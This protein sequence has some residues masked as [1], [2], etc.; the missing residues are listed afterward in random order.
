MVW[1]PKTLDGDVA[2]S[3]APTCS[4]IMEEKNVAPYGK[5]NGTNLDLDLD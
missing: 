3:V 4:W 1:G 2:G 5:G